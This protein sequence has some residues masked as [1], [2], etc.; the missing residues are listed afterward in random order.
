[1]EL[2]VVGTLAFAF[3][4]IVETREW[5]TRRNNKRE[6]EAMQRKMDRVRWDKEDWR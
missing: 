4:L 6:K 3:I 5:W 1:M 2:M